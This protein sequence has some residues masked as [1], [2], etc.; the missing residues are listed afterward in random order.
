MDT[1]LAYYPCRATET[2]SQGNRRIRVPAGLSAIRKQ[3]TSARS[4]RHVEWP[5]LMPF[6]VSAAEYARRAARA[7]TAGRRRQSRSA[8]R[9]GWLRWM[10]GRDLVEQRRRV[11]CR[12]RAEAKPERKARIMPQRGSSVLWVPTDGSLP[13]NIVGGRPFRCS[14]AAEP[15]RRSR[16]NP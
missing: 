10:R 2:A 11:A 8:R 3:S 15:P 1:G 5:A 14:R 12:G 16:R 7:R 9:N 4:R 13:I 6:S